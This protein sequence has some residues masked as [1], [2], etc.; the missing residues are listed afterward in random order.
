MICMQLGIIADIH[1]NS[2]ALESVLEDAKR[3]G[4][5]QF[6]DLGDV[7]YG[8]MEPLRTF[9]LLKTIDAALG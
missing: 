7:L 8:P 4:I 3:R 5:R 6:V 2:R 9:E 1:G